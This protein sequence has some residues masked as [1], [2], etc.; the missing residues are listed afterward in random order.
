MIYSHW[1]QSEFVNAMI[2]GDAD[3]IN[4]LSAY[5]KGRQLHGISQLMVS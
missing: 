5:S 2:V 1:L 4:M 3:Q